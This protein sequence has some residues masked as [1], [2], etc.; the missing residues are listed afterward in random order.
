[1]PSTDHARRTRAYLAVGLGVPIVA[2]LAAI[3]VQTL[4]TP[5]ST[6]IGVHWNLHGDVDRWAAAWTVLVATLIAGLAPAGLAV[7]NYLPLRDG[8]PG[9]FFRWVSTTAASLS[10]SLTSLLTGVVIAQTDGAAPSPMILVAVAAAC[11]SITAAIVWMIQPNDLTPAETPHHVEPITI[12]VGGRVA[13]LRTQTSSR[14]LL[15]LTWLIAGLTIGTAV[16]G[17]A[18]G[19]PMTAVWA[20]AVAS[21][22]VVAALTSSLSFHVR[23]DG[24]GLTIRS[25]AGFPRWHVAAADI[26]DVRLISVRAIGQFGGYGVRLANGRTGVILRSGEALEVHRR[27]GRPIVLTVDDAATAAAVLTAVSSADSR[28]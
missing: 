22:I 13:W 9:R 11:G 24:S 17:W 26:I 18:C 16:V 4:S 15:A 14:G 8:T 10:V 1:M 23:I 19:L 20:S 25:I 6:W 21:L 12:G 28:P 2:T 27:T 5:P 3:A 7:V